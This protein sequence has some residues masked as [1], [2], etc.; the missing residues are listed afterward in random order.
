M[1]LFCQDVQFLGKNRDQADEKFEAI[2]LLA[3]VLT[4][5]YCSL[6]E[7]VTYDS[8][9]RYKS[10]QLVHF[11]TFPLIHICSACTIRSGDLSSVT[12]MIEIHELLYFATVCKMLC[13]CGGKGL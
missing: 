5:G 7:W 1:A 11:P 12:R 4:G 2:P 9:Y 13:L 10:V 6:H 8:L 3:S